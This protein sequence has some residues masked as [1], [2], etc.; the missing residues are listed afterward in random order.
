M[1][2]LCEGDNSDYIYRWDMG[3][4]GIVY[5]L[6]IDKNFPNR[7][8]ERVGGRASYNRVGRTLSSAAFDPLTFVIPTPRLSFRAVRSPAGGARTC[9]GACFCVGRHPSFSGRDAVRRLPHPSRFSKRGKQADHVAPAAVV[10]RPFRAA[11][12][13][14]PDPRADEAQ[15]LEVP[16]CGTDTPVVPIKCPQD[17]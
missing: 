4:R 17:P 9:R 7:E 3:L 15:L 16:M 5:F 1:R 6:P 12:S 2:L 10:E 11:P 13:N 8:S 14:Q